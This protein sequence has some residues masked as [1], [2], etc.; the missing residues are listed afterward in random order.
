MS[1]RSSKNCELQNAY[2]ILHKEHLAKNEELEMSRAREQ[3]LIE[4]L[5]H[6]LAE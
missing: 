3:G 5:Q 4:Q 2:D 1:S 6:E